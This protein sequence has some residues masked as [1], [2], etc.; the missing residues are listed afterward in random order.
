LATALQFVDEVTVESPQESPALRTLARFFFAT[1]WMVVFTG[2]VRKWI[3]PG[4]SAL[5]LLQDIPLVAGYAY[6]L[7]TGLFT[8]GYMLLSLLLLSLLLML[9]G[10][11]QILISGLDV[12]IAL[13]GFHNY[14]LYLPMLVVFPLCLTEKYRKNFVWWNLILSIPV[15]VLAVAQGQAPRAAWIN[16]TSEGEAFGVPG[17]EVEVARVS[18]TFNFVSFYSI[19][20]AMVVA[21][22]M[23]E[24]LLPKHR[25]AVRN[26]WLLLLCTFTAN[27]CHLISASR[28]AVALSG[29][30]ILGALVGAIV[31]GSH[32]A[33]LAI[34][35]IILLVPVAAGFTYVISPAEFKIM[36]QRFTGESEVG[37]SKNRLM[38]GLIGFAYEPPFS[39]VGAGIGVGTDAAHIGSI[40]A[41]NFT[42]L[43]SEYDIIRNVMELGTVVGLIYVLARIVFIVGMVFL[44]IRIVRNGSSPHVLPLSFFLLA[45]SY[46]ADWTRGATMSC[47]QVMI[48]YSFILGAYFYPDTPSQEPAAGELL[49][50]SV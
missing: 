47:S 50:R 23:G 30:A 45:Q 13:V 17:A 41:Y 35:G 4:T 25:R 27:M 12:F 18:G 5:Y 36:Q 43:L 2:S 10:L 1:F 42:Y 22:C 15:S 38:E 6:A 46:Q 3:F 7:W 29:L 26:T 33:M 48:G 9:Q 21:L 11:A 19:W 16:K 37:D 44:S 31:L 24:W 40:D 14:L 8:R 34:A 32:R 20:V 28:T 49:T 39:L